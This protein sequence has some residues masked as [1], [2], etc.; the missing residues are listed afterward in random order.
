MKL[1]DDVIAI[2]DREFSSSVVDVHS[3]KHVLEKAGIT[4]RFDEE[5]AE[6]GLEAHEA[7]AEKSFGIHKIDSPEEPFV[8]TVAIERGEEVFY[9]DARIWM[10]SS[11]RFYY[12][13][14]LY[15]DMYEVK[16]Y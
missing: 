10:N 7:N 8:L 11:Y 3:M 1:Y 6:K 4:V 5:L 12:A 14:A 16:I 13:I 9:M 15:Y 2:L